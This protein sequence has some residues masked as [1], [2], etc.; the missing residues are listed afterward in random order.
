M[1]T[2]HDL[3]IAVLFLVILVA[4]CLVA[5]GFTDDTGEL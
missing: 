4:P 2:M 3:F 1:F 5:L